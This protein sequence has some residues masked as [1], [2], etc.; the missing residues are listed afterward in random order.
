MLKQIQV[1]TSGR[2]ESM[3][4]HFPQACHPENFRESLSL[5]LFRLN[6]KS[7]TQNKKG[8]SLPLTFIAACKIV[9]QLWRGHCG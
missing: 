9:L 1:N 4:K 7:E 8:S 6:R 5:P 2:S 3:D